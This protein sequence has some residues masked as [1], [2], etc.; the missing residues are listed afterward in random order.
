[1]PMLKPG[2]SS[3]CIR[4]I[5]SA[6]ERPALPDHARSPDNVPAA[7]ET[8]A[9]NSESERASSLSA[10]PASFGRTCRHAFEHPRTSF[11]LVSKWASRPLS[12]PAGRGPRSARSSRRTLSSHA[13][14]ASPSPPTSGCLSRASSGTGARSS[15]CTDAIARSRVPGANSDK[16]CPALSSA[17]MS[18]RR[19]RADTLRASMRSGVTSAAVLPGDSSASRIASAIAWA[20]AAWS[21]NS[22]ARIPVSLR[23]AGRRLFHLSLK[24]AA[25]IACAIA[26]ERTAGEAALPDDGQSCTSSRATPIRSSRSFK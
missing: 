9:A 2:A 24:S 19:S 21:G 3:A 6:A 26:R 4:D 12:P 17:S 25:V 23:S 22:T 18:Q 14:R 5:S 15:D 1:M 11:S 16:G 7:S 8:T 10:R 20:S 13:R